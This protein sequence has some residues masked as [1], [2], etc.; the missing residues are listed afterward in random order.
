MDLS[1]FQVIKIKGIYLYEK[2]EN[3]IEIHKE[4]LF[5]EPVFGYPPAYDYRDKVLQK[6][7]VRFSKTISSLKLHWDSVL[8]IFIQSLLGSPGNYS[9]VYS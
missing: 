1:H 8:P 2:N 7:S 3:D 4:N 9:S 6:V 5:Q